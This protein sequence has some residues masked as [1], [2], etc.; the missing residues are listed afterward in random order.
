M[1]KF[2]R[3]IRQ[4]LLNEGKITRY[5]KYAIGEILLVV[6][7][8]LIA[9]SI[10]NWNNNK[11]MHRE[12]N[13]FNQRLLAEVNGNIDLGINRMAE[14]QNNINSSKEILKLFDKQ[15]NDA[16]LK[17]LD[18]LIYIVIGSVRIEYGIGTLSEGLN[19]GKVALINSE[20][21]KSKLYGLPSN[22]E[23]V[24][25]HDKFYNSFTDEY[26]QPFLYKNFNFRNM[27]HTYSGYDI[28]PSKFNSQH[29]IALLE[30]EEFENLIDNY[31]YTK[32][33]QL[34]FHL[35][36][37]KEFEHIRNLIEVELDTGK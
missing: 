16:N 24:R 32:N 14:I 27:D 17:S 33:R 7:G 22:I 19:T 18:S 10:N 9:L 25:D 15:F 6:I 34:Q 2:F 20:I 31:F 3:N 11:I 35:N 29:N 12:S 36:L 37:K 21:L 23:Y 4:N 30:N 28:G 5:F 26:L 1:I 13:K 8:I